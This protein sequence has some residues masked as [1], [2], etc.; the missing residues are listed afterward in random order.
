MKTALILLAVAIVA[1]SARRPK[2]HELEG[3][4]FAKYVE[5]FGKVYSPDE[6]VIREAIFTQRLKEVKAHNAGGY[7]WKKGV[8]HLTDTTVAERK[9]MNGGRSTEM[10]HLANKDMQVPFVSSGAPLPNAVDYRN[11]IPSVL[12]TVKDQGYCGSCWA[13]GST[14]TMESMIAI[15]TGEL[16]VLSQQEI[17]ACAPNPDECGGTGG[18]GGSIAELAFEYAAIHGM[19][20]EWEYPYTSYNGT[21]GKCLPYAGKM[22]K[23]FTGYTKLPQNDR[24]AIMQALATVGPLA[25]NV[26][27]SQWPD[28]HGGIFAG[29]DYAK[30]ISLD[31]V[32]QL[33]GYGTD[34]ESG[35]DYW[36][37][38]NSW[39]ATFGEAGFIRVLRSKV[40]EECGWN[41]KPQDGVGCK[42]G[43][44]QQWTC[45]MC[46]LLYDVSY[47]TVKN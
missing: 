22:F 10:G 8:N 4:T 35:L 40:E 14:E 2:L 25:I 42:G 32:V 20:Q 43:P 28:Y 12:T 31:H 6:Y 46:G 38:R 23:D 24:H 7:S 29:C 36:I 37:V 30:N 15:R 26:D 5:D 18:C 13:H 33:V 44:K 17:N 41:V 45:G 21:T 27:A 11:S 16:F 9:R 34:L 19:T 1:V 3:Y 47:P 39:S